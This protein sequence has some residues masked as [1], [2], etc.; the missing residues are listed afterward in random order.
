MPDPVQQ[1]P[2]RLTPLHA[3]LSS[4]RRAEQP[5]CHDGERFV[6][7][8]DFVRQ[9][10][11]RAR[12]FACREEQ[13]WLL[14]DRNPFDF[15]IA[16]MA[17]LQAGKVVVIPPNS[18]PGTIAQLAACHD[19]ISGDE[20]AIEAGDDASAAGIWPLRAID[21][22]QAIIDIYTSG[23]TG[24]PKRVRK[25]LAQFEAEVAVLEALWGE[26]LGDAVILAT[27]PHHH[28]YGLLFRLLWPLSAGRSF[29]ATTCGEPEQLVERLAFFGDTALVSS[30]AQ[31][32]RLPQMGPLTVLQP[33]PKFLF[34]SG[35]A[36][37]A[38]A[39]EQYRRQ[40]GRAPIEV[41]GSTET[42]GIAWRRQEGDDAWSA[43]PGISIA[44]DASGALML[45]SPFLAD[46]AW[47]RM[48]DAVDLLPGSRFRL[49]GRLDRIVKIEEKR[50]SLPDLEARLGEHAWIANAAALALSGRRQSVGV[51]L[52]L[53]PEGRLQL[54][55]NGRRKVVQELRRHL[56]SHFETV[57]LPR[58]WRFPEQ[59]PINERGKL[60]QAALAALFAQEA[61]SDSGPD[62][63]SD[64]A[65]AAT[66]AV[67]EASAKPGSRTPPASCAEP[68][69]T[70]TLLPEVLSRRS[71]AA[72][73]V[74]AS[75]STAG[76]PC[77][78][79]IDLHVPAALEHFAG[80]F[81]G[82][83]ILPGVVQIHWATYFARAHLPVSGDFSL[84]ENVKFQALLL[85]DARLELTLDW[86]PAKRRLEFS[87][88]NR[89]RKFSSG[90]IVFGGER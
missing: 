37:S 17:L 74:S 71:N 57:L 50:L 23:S 54:A 30:P 67:Q 87:Y 6:A 82:L 18:Q 59:L 28:I 40:L 20:G 51:A 42:G 88:A 45:K 21:P 81:P 19:A 39:T 85:P 63:G 41:F 35:G 66:G 8:S 3:L 68:G 52:V 27:T 70:N 58:H 10:Q 15:L 60:T 4:A 43:F 80:H 2:S 7:W 86:D 47:L 9:V 24:E 29:D 36:L 75:D 12:A 84:L 69:A 62:S 16:L 25:T 65:S 77:R 38:A 83:P 73:E 32:A 22:Q 53:S 55:R 90:R 78:M 61:G 5:V 64:A 44:T 14:T 49:R 11:L 56:A 46:A 48:E 89:D 34:S 76:M 33:L 26:L 13:R 31:L 1:Q 79:V 72:S